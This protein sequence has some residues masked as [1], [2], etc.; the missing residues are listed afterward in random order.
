[1]EVN[2]SSDVKNTDTMVRGSYMHN[3]VIKPTRQIILPKAGPASAKRD[4][5]GANTRYTLHH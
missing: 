2:A 4:L 5:T 3:A 1:M